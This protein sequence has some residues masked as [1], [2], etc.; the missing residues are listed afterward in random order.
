MK[1]NVKTIVFVFVPVELSRAGFA[2][3][4]RECLAAVEPP[5]PPEKKARYPFWTWFLPNP[6][7]PVQRSR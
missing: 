5:A 4:L 1:A 3:P 2:R 6:C 7:V